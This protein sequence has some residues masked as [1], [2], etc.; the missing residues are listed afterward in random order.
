MS[1]RADRKNC[2]GVVSTIEPE[3][4]GAT[5]VVGELLPN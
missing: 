4:A 2:I 1:T 5:A 3:V